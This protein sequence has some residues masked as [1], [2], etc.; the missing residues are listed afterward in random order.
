MST[1]IQNTFLYLSKSRLANRLARR[2]GL[3]L[4]ARRFVAGETV[5]EAMVRVKAFNDRGIQATVDHLGEFVTSRAEAEAAAAAAIEALRAMDRA[6]VDAYLS[7][8]LTQL[9][10]DVDEALAHAHMRR[11]LSEAKRRGR[12]VRIDIE[13]YARNEAT[14]RLFRALLDE[15]GPET[16]GIAMQAYLYKSADD[17]EALL[18]DR[19]NIRFVKG[20]YKEPPSVVYPNK[21]DVDE[22]YFRL[23]ARHL[24]AGG[25]AAVATH[26]ERLIERVKAYVREAGIPR[27]R[28]EFQML[29]GIKE[30]L[31]ER[32]AR[33][34]Y[35]ARVYV[36]YGIDWY[37]YTMRRLA[38]RPENAWFVLRS[39]FAR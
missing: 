6:G 37:G 5:E 34:G 39:L 8:K 30:S 3:R 4:G 28:F 29:Y 10:L 24:S 20:A 16:I 31:L 21:A 11:I 23:V 14:F 33:E 13:D 36:P 18:P 25:Y 19:P 7:V 15:F 2:Y 17:L 26:D 27:E 22:N 35:T 12:F 1:F 9:G 38:E 32:L